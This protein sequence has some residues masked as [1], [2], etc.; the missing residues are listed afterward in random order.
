MY[1]TRHEKLEVLE[2]EKSDTFV[3]SDETMKKFSVSGT[4]LVRVLVVSVSITVLYEC[5][6]ACQM[7]PCTSAC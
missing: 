7:E 4:S 6:L 3:L 5:C 2:G 1:E